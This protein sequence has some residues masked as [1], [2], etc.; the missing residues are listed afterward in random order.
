MTELLRRPEVVVTAELAELRVEFDKLG[1][2]LQGMRGRVPK[3]LFA[4]YIDVTSK[5]LKLNDELR[6]MRGPRGE[7]T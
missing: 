4:R 6:V 7:D 2:E 1:A 5:M 3:G